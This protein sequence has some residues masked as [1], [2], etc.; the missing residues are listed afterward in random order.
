MAGIMV[1]GQLVLPFVAPMSVISNKPVFAMDTMNLSRLIHGQ[2]AQ[3]WEIKTNVM[4]QNSAVDFFAHSVVNGYDAI[5]DIQMPQPYR[6]KGVTK[7]TSNISASGSAGASSVTISGNS[8][9]LRKGDFV[10][11]TG[12]SK[13]YMV[14]ADI[15][16]N[17]S[18][19][20]FPK[21]KKNVAE[22]MQHGDAVM[23]QATYDDANVLGMVY[24]D[25]IITDPGQIT[26]I[27]SI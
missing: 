15:T 22:T 8:G 13:T 16:G 26:F 11:F 18:M 14:T 3:R 1:G 21:L 7:N 25:G 9:T 17:G 20:I 2:S 27:E 19:G 6:G 4:P 12:H 23:F 24:T 10:R 5:F